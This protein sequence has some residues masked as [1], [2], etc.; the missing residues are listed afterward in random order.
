M[1][2]GKIILIQGDM[3]VYVTCEFNGDVHPNR[4]GKEILDCFYEDEPGMI[5][6]ENC[7]EIGIHTLNLL[8][9]FI[10]NNGIMCQKEV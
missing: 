10:S 6:D 2:R 4:H 3:Q 1:T 7:Q 9:D 8:Y 5:A